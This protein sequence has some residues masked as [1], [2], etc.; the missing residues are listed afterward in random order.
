[1]TNAVPEAIDG[2][3]CKNIECDEK[4]LYRELGGDG[5]FCGSCGKR[6]TQREYED[7]VKLVHGH[8]KGKRT[9]A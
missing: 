9:A 7:W 3:P 5:V 1:L 6:Y 8:V 4:D 2:V